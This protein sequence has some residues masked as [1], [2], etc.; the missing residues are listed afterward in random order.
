MFLLVGCGGGPHQGT[1]VGNPGNLDVSI[2]EI[3]E[4][5]ELDMADIHAADLVLIGCDGEAALVPVQTTL[6]AL[7]PSIVDVSV[8]PGLWC[9]A[10][11]TLDPEVDGQILLGGS[12][13]G[14]TD[15]T[16]ALELG[17]IP[18]QDTFFV[19]GT[20][21]LLVLPL[22]DILDVSEIESR[23]PL[24][25][26]G[27]DDPSALDWAGQL[28][29]RANLYEDQDGNGILTEPDTFVGG[30]VPDTGADA[31]AY[32]DSAQSGGCSCQAGSS[33]GWLWLFAIPLLFRRRERPGTPG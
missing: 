1:A 27:A 7:G 16:V 21:L 25:D 9:G 32:A 5:V 11:L 2:G 26:I 33:P 8:P 14:G 22:K 15:F 6:D 24:V 29:E 4:E 20:E 31:A 30:A 13:T 10:L 23:G 19:D 28:G 12:T 17:S 3:P 18:L